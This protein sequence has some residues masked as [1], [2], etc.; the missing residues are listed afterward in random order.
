MFSVE[1]KGPGLARA[2]VIHTPHGDIETPA[3][4]A[5]GTKAT[6]KALTPAQLEELGAEAVLGNT[7]HL[8]LEPGDELIAKGGGMAKFM[9]WK[10]P[11]F[12]DSGGFQVF[13]LG[14]AFGKQ[15]TKFSDSPQVAEEVEDEQTEHVKL[16]EVDEEGVTFSSY[17]NGSKHRFT[18]ERSMEIQHNLGA[19]IM[20]AFDEFTRPTASREE[21]EHSLE[22]THRWAA[23]SLE[24][25]R[26]AKSPQALFGIVQGGRDEELRKK[27]AREIG[28]MDFAGFG[29]GG[30]FTKKDLTETLGWVN[31]ILPEEK[32]RHLLGI[33]E[34]GDLFIGVLRGIDT[35]DCVAPTRRARGGTL[36]TRRGTVNILNEKYT[37]VLEPLERECG[38]YTC[39]HFTIAY[40]SHLYRNRE[41]LA[42]VLGSMHNLYFI[43]NLV[44]EM[45]GHLLAGTLDAFRDEYLSRYTA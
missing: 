1:K 45:R 18:P 35:F 17:R 41:I 5:V 33:G 13:S 16:A 20:F 19:D 27:S 12:T 14:V 44:K 39:R 34:P 9:N 26:K 8:Y 42:S 30:T 40:L 2:G 7:Y 37:G 10:K 21:H 36:Y 6:V 28:G 31:A 11:T 43:I 24:H 29:I 3:F 38:C 23:R 15:I 4:I 32:P 25:H 22:R